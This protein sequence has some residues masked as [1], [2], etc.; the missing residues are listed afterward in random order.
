MTDICTHFDVG[1]FAYCCCFAVAI[2][3]KCLEEKKVGNYCG[4]AFVQRKIKDYNEA[5]QCSYKTLR[6]VSG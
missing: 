2:S 5:V 6:C 4:F 1:I 3:W